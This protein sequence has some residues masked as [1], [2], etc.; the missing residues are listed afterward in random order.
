MKTYVQ[1]EKEQQL[2]EEQ[3]DV[4]TLRQW[5]RNILKEVDENYDPDDDSSDDEAIA[6][7][8]R[9]VAAIADKEAEVEAAAA[10]LKAGGGRPGAKK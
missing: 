6:E 7:R 8:A 9:R 2:A 5:E 1:V 3:D 10:A 4:K